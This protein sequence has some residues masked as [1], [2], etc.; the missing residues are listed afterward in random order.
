MKY[1]LPILALTSTAIAQKNARFLR[2]ELSGE[3]RTLTL[4]E[5]EINSG[6]KNIAKSGKATQS[7]TGSGGIASRAIDGNKNPSFTNG[8]Q[9]HTEEGKKDP[10]WELDLGKTASVDSVEIWNRGDDG[11][12]DRLQ[13]F[14]LSLMDR[15]H[16][17][18]FISSRT[19]CPE[20]SVLFDFQK[21][22]KITF[23]KANGKEI[24]QISVPDNYRDPSP[25]K[26]MK[27]DTVAIVGNGL[28]DR[29][30]HDG[31]TETLIQAGAPGMDLRFRNMSLTGDRP[32][33]QPRSNGFIPMPEYLKQV[34]ADVIIAMFGY[35]E[36]F[37][38]K[39]ED[40]EKNLTQ[41]IEVFRKAMPNGESLPRIVL[42]SPI[43]H[44]NLKDHNLPTGRANNKRLLAITEATR[45]AAEISGVAYVA[46]Y[47]P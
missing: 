38:T 15:N 24:K 35:N 36:S 47:N 8:G 30:Q 27:G 11:L 9:T 14:K 34:G 22:G 41:M 20:S 28:A 6:G 12:G 3:A 5:V 10:W 29:M 16:R 21:S 25:F 40:H 44:E 19:D 4:A 42:C 45:V 26:F 17:P 2:I 33:K 18:V 13:G 23:I 43:A 32:N 1:L 39:P 31:W 7:T 46:L 37:D